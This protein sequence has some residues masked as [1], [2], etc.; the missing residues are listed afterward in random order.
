MSLAYAFADVEADLSLVEGATKDCPGCD[1][2]NPRAAR[3]DEC[4]T[5]DGT[6]RVPLAAVEIAK[7]LKAA[8]AEKDHV[9]ASYE[10]E[11][12]DDGMG[13]EIDPDLLLEG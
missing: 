10:D 12:G 13:G 1:A 3:R 6:G 9:S 2:D 8:R 11:D 7:E 4:K 5:C